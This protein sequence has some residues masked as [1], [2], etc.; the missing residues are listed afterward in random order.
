MPQL[1]SNVFFH[2]LTNV[3]KML[4]LTRRPKTNLER[5]DPPLH[6][7]TPYKIA[8]NNNHINFMFNFRG[9]VTLEGLGLGPHKSKISHWSKLSRL[10]S[11][12]YTRLV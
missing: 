7:N 3:K 6:V 2:I 4:V 9:G 10:V 5:S 11:W 8:L 1:R 12:A